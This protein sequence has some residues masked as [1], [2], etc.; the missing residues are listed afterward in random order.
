MGA[1]R[2]P[3]G[4]EPDEGTDSG[5]VPDV[6]PAS[7][8][9]SQVP[10][11]DPRWELIDQID[12]DDNTPSGAPPDPSQRSW[13]HPSEVAAANAHMGR[14]LA[15]D[16]RRQHPA[17]QLGG[18]YRS[19]PVGSGRL[20]L[21]AAAGALV[22]A[23]V[24]IWTNSPDTVISDT[25]AVVSVASSTPI[26][27]LA[28]TQSLAPVVQGPATT[29]TTIE[30]NSGSAKA[31]YLETEAAPPP[32]AFEVLS[33]D[34]TSSTLAT[35]IRIDGLAPE[36]LIT[37]ASAIGVRKEVMLADHTSSSDRPA[38]MPALVVGTDA[39]SD[40]AV[41]RVGI[42]EESPFSASIGSQELSELG[43]DVEIRSGVP[44]TSHSG[45]ILSITANLIE[46]SAPVPNA[47]LGAAVVNTLGRVIGVVVDS[48]SMLASAIPAAECQRIASNIADYGVANPNWLGI[49]ITSNDGVVEVVDVVTDGP[50]DQAGLEVGDRLLGAGGLVVVTPDQLSDI[51]SAQEPGTELNLVVERDSSVDTVVITIGQ[52]PKTPL[53]PSWVDT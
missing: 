53:S 48:P 14:F 16:A 42:G 8:D 6:D 47:H 50:A 1:E 19:S 22:I 51:V 18:Q 3:E 26:L 29:T 21:A 27:G 12:L 36:F 44:S 35:A 17:S 33:E 7:I 10:I 52:R 20:I 40:I 37:S 30:V 2:T 4:P 15:E 45:K 9:W 25:A 23:G 28:E 32:W 24:S 46:T 49:T 5:S 39:G 31:L 11:D 13:R 43:S 41:L 34:D 38:L